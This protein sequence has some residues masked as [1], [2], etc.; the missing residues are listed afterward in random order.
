MEIIYAYVDTCVLADIICQYDPR[1]IHG[2]FV[3]GMFI[4][5]KML[6]Y[7]NRIVE[8]LE[9]SSGY[10]V[11]STF[12]FVELIN[13]FE[14]IF[15]GTNVT[16][17]RIMSIMSQPPSWLIIE[18]INDRTALSYCDVPNSIN[19]ESISSD[20]AV[21]I[22]TAFQRGDSILFMTTDH[23]LNQLQVANIT[24]ISS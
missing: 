1:S 2:S 4:K 9:E 8:D 20:D 7:I 23:I 22:A 16:I 5:K 3:E 21:H 14:K 13:K 15:A 18:E 11:S 24:F 6:K 19:G 17:E 12:A 10:L